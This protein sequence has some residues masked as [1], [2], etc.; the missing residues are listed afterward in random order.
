[1]ITEGEKEMA[2]TDFS[3]VIEPWGSAPYT[4]PSPVP[5]Y[6]RAIWKRVLGFD[7]WDEWHHISE[8]GEFALSNSDPRFATAV[9][10]RSIIC[11]RAEYLRDNHLKLV[12][13]LK[14][15]CR[16]QLKTHRPGII[17]TLID[18][19]LFGLG[20]LRQAQEIKS[21]LENELKKVLD[22]YDRLWRVVIDLTSRNPSQMHEVRA[23]R[24]IA[25]NRK[26]KPPTRYVEPSPFIIV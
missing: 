6:G 23:D 25:E 24:L 9:K 19:E 1:M 22:E 17:Y 8:E 18:T 3:I 21:L 7:E 20:H 11:V 12:T 15:A 4:F 14:D 10:R 2:S 5:A 16:R 26:L 13:T